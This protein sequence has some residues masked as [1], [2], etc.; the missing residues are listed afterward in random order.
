MER[1]ER[2]PQREL[3]W[4]VC[5]QVYKLVLG[6]S[7]LTVLALMNG[8]IHQ[9]LICVLRSRVEPFTP[10]DYIINPP[11]PPNCTSLHI[12]H[13]LNLRI[14]KCDPPLVSIYIDSYIFRSYSGHEALALAAW[15]RRCSVS[16]CTMYPSSQCQYFV[17]HS[18]AGLCYSGDHI[19]Y[20]VIDGFRFSHDESVE[21]IAFVINQ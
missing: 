19:D 14:D 17:P 5:K 1:V 15:L 2:R 21:L 10:V 18:N 9:L 11:P 8:N 3:S 16:P 12:R 4:E 13:D 20:L 6:A 7:I